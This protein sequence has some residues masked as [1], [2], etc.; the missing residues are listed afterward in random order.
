[1]RPNKQGRRIE[2]DARRARH[3]LH[4]LAIVLLFGFMLIALPRIIDYLTTPS[5]PPGQ[6]EQPRPLH[7]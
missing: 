1:M 7:G 3:F 4:M 5:L 6:L 2:R